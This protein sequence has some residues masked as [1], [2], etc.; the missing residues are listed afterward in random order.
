MKIQGVEVDVESIAV[1]FYDIILETG[2]EAVVAFGMIPKE[3]MDLSE[4]ALREKI[5]SDTAKRMGMTPEEFEPWLDK[6]KLSEIVRD[7]QHQV[8]IAILGV[9]KR[10]G[11]MCV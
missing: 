8:C 6:A 9:A 10:N 5:I 2:M 3:L 7:I 4:K 11:M 1:G